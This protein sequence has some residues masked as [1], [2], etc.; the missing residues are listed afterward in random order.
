MNIRERLSVI[1]QIVNASVDTRG[2]VHILEFMG[3]SAF[4]T[5][6]LEEIRLYSEYLPKAQELT[7]TR[8]QRYLHFLWDA[9]DKLPISVAVNFA[10]PFRRI[11]AK[12]LFKKCGKNFIAEENV[13]FNF[14]QNL[15]L[16]NDVFMNRGVYLDA[17]GG[18]ILG[19]FVALAEGVEIYTHT[20]SE[21]EHSKRSYS[22][23]V[24][25]DFAKIYAHAMI[26]PGVTV[27]EQAVVAAKSLVSKNVE[28]NMVVAGIPAKVIRERKTN[29]R[30]KG[31]LDHI[32]FYDSAFQNE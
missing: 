9:L 15:E 11:I 23:V 32:W 6:I 18:I 2:A 16:G 19:D 3:A 17:K 5:E 7:F 1:E 28:P 26:L 29:G 31:E 30:M 14:G 13:R 20:H 27:G 8:E 21:S 10:I 25:K 12:R 24:I 22:R 4:P